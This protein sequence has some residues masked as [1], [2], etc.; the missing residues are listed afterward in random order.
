MG[1]SDL[2][3]DPLDRPNLPSFLLAPKQAQPLAGARLRAALTGWLPKREGKRQSPKKITDPKRLLMGPSVT[4]T[5]PPPVTP[6]EPKLQ[7]RLISPNQPITSPSR[8]AH[9]P[10]A[11][12]VPGRAL[13][14]VPNPPKRRPPNKWLRPALWGLGG[15]FTLALIAGLGVTIA[16]HPAAPMQ[17]TSG[18]VLPRPSFFAQVGAGFGLR[19]QEVLV[20]GRIRSGSETIMESLQTRRGEA[21]LGL[22]VEAAR[23]RLEALPW[24]LSAVV[25]R[26]LPD[27]VYVRLTERS[28]FALWQNGGRFHL[29]DS[30]GVT[31]LA[32]WGLMDPSGEFASLPVIVG[33]GAPQRAEE[34]LLLLEGEPQIKPLVAAVV[35]VGDRRWN[36]R[37]TNGI[38]VRLPEENPA[39]ALGVLADLHRQQKLLDRDIVA[40]DLRQADRMIV[41]LSPTAAVQKQVNGGNG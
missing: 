34:I 17:N 25:E 3:L 18:L 6:I 13:I 20:E 35:R 19:V 4:P 5:A 11:P 16:L 41:Q 32:D 30:K 39:V 40:I 23:Q 24:I 36:L 27:T 7:A 26:R 37:L 10:V 14:V 33:E 29:V 2:H 15:T 8:K 38:D 22:D 9:P 1:M 12:K 21:I 31:I 28:P